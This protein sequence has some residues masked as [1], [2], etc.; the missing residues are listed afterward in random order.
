[1]DE[2]KTLFEKVEAEV[3]GNAGE[4]FKTKVKKKLYQIG[5]VSLFIFLAFILISFGIVML[6]GDAFPFL[7]NG[8][9]FLILGIIY[10]VLGF[11]LSR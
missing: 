10:L 11:V 4:F 1:M 8:F 2:D 6:I 9:N 3:I 5:E 7:D